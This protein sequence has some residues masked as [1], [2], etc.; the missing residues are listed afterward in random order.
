[1]KQITVCITI[2]AMATILL[3][4][5]C[6]TPSSNSCDSDF[7]QLAL[8]SNIGTNIIVPSYQTLAIE[9]ATL[10]SDALTFASNPT[11]S[12]L[13]VLRNQLQQIWL[14][15]Q[16]AGIFQLGPA[17]TEQFRSHMDNFPVFTVRL[18]LAVTSG[19]YD[20]TTEAYSYARG[21][22]ALDYLLYGIGTTASDIVDQYTTDANASN[23]KQYL[24]DVTALILQKAN[25]VNDAWKT[26]GGNYLA[27]FIGTDGVASGKPLSDLVN[28]LNEGYEKFKN[29][30]LLIPISAITSYIPLL[31]EN[32]EAYYSR[33][34][35]D[36]AI[37]AVQAVKKVFLGY[38]N[39]ADNIGLD[40]YLI[41][42]EAK[43]NNANLHTLIIDQYDLAISTL[44]DLKPSSLH[45]AINNN[46][47][48]V[49]IAYAAAQNQMVLTKTDMASALCV[50]ITYIDNV[51]DGD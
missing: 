27:T 43:K 15:W 39:G 23:R 1:M 20:L 18:D 25:T 16:T 11:T 33:T 48:G 40:D 32:V 34:S 12:N 14:T 24:R 2:L 26:D 3:F 31:P 4:S 44:N 47:D 30:K 42:V 7:D 51:D 21:F 38:T 28:Q 9:A 5:G 29:N 17:Y 36:L 35:L 13:T 50:S 8:L 45:D 49:K 10:N 46:L 6:K 19:T 37:A 41:A 22:P